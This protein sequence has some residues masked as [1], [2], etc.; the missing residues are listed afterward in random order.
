LSLLLAEGLAQLAPFG[1][2]NPTPQFATYGLHISDDRRMGREGTHRKLTVRGD[3]ATDSAGESL[4][5]V[6]FGGAD[7]ELP[8]GPIDLLYTLNINEYK[9]ERSL[10]LMYVD[11]RPAQSRQALAVPESRP[12]LHVVDLRRAENATVLHATL[13]E[14]LT[15]AQASA[16]LQPAEQPVA[17]Y[18]EGVRLEP[19]PPGVGYSPRSQ[20]QRI[21]A[22]G[23]GPQSPQTALI[24]WSIPPSPDLLR[25]LLDTVRPAQVYIC[26]RYTADDALSSVLRAVAGMCKFA[27][28]HPQRGE[29]PEP[30]P[31]FLLNLNRMAARLG[32]TEAIVRHALLWLEARGEI[33]LVEWQAGDTVRLAAGGGQV[34][35]QA[36]QQLEVELEE[37][38]AEVRAYRRFFQRAALA[39]LNLRLPDAA[40]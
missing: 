14:T 35:P 15:Q 6:W 16:G 5:V 17:W 12:P 26:A 36:T 13:T 27:L 24:L 18:A 25:W 3:A 29:T 4:P 8:S 34:R 9:G 10:Q 30:Q 2:G 11:S 23:A 32:T 20:L 38:L 21:A 33:H 31:L 40:P 22:P 19:L 28:N 37:M 1:A 7:A 39:D